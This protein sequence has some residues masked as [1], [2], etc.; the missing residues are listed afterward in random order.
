MS[1]HWDDSGTR[2]ELRVVFERLLARLSDLKLDPDVPPTRGCNPG[3]E[4]IER[5]PVLRPR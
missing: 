2:M 3:F 5:M 4:T 1:N